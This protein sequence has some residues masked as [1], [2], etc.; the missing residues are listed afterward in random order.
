VPRKSTAI[1]ARGGEVKK[2]K[3]Q[4]DQRY[5]PQKLGN[6]PPSR[7]KKRAYRLKNKQ[8][9]GEG[10]KG[11]GEKEPCERASYFKQSK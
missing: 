2:K 5:D 4:T 11:K 1:P 8:R 10:K 6:V 9:E 7:I 3:K